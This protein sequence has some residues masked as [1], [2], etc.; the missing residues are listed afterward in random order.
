MNRLAR[1]EADRPALELPTAQAHSW[2]GEHGRRRRRRGGRRRLGVGAPRP[3]P[4]REGARE[5][6]EIAEPL[7]RRMTVVARVGRLVVER[8]QQA[9][10]EERVELGAHARPVERGRCAEP[11]DAAELLGSQPRLPI[12]QHRGEQAL[13]LDAQRQALAEVGQRAGARARVVLDRRHQRAEHAQRLLGEPRV[14][15]EAHRGSPADQVVPIG[16]LGRHLAP[17]L[18]AAADPVIHPRGGPIRASRRRRA[19]A[20]STIDRALSPLLADT[21]APAPS[22]VREPRSRARPC[23]PVHVLASRL[24]KSIRRRARGDEYG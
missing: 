5:R 15:R 8:A 20:A 1:A 9:Q 11:R 4:A 18:C 16:N 24:R 3:R 22:P 6:R 19:E 17:T 10:A 14:E 2:R 13:L 21:Q 23:V 12:D 7:A